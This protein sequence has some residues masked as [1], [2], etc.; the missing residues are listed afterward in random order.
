MS[1]RLA[2]ALAAL[3]CGVGPF[4]AVPSA[5][6]APAGRNNDHDCEAFEANDDAI[7]GDLDAI[8]DVVAGYY[9]S[10][11]GNSFFGDEQYGDFDADDMNT[12]LSATSSLSA[13]AD[14]VKKGMQTRGAI[15]ALDRLANDSRAVNDTARKIADG[16]YRPRQL[17][18][19]KDML[20]RSMN[21]YHN[22]H[23]LACNGDIVEPQH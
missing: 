7:Q 9:T 14:S 10:W 12:I 17:G 22:A 15:L 5:L 4:V 23:S 8:N 20:F 13:R 16:T 18:L 11:V 1:L 21:N 19:V 3:A 2:A 6:A